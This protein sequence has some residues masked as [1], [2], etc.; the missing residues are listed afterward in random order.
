MKFLKT[1]KETFISSLPLVAIIII[2]CFFVE[3]M[4]NPGDYLKLSI[5]YIAVVVGQTIFLNGLDFSILPIGKLVGGSLGKIKKVSI[6]LLIGFL[7]GLLATVAEPAIIVLARQTNMIMGVIKENVFIWVSSIGIGIFVAFSLYRILRNF[8]IKI[9]FLILYVIIFAMILFVPQEFIALAFDGSG[10]TT[11]DISVPFILALGL[12][13][14]ATMSKTKT[15]EDTFGIIGLAS[16]GPIIALF[17][18]GIIMKWVHGGS[19]PPSGIYNPGD[20]GSL[21]E[22][23]LSNIGGVALTIIPIILVFLPFQFL[24]I[25]LNKKELSSLML[26]MMAVFIGLLIFLSGIDYGFAFAGKY[27]GEVFLNPT[28]PEWFKWMLLIVAFVLGAAITFTEPAVTILGEQLETTTNGHIKKSTIRV[29]LAIGIGFASLLAM[30]KILT[31]I[32]IV[33][34]LAPLYLIALIMMKF[35]SK[36]FVGLAFDSGGVTG[37]ALTSAF[38]TPLTLGAAQAIAVA[39]GEGAQSV[40]INGFGI[41]AFVSVTPLIAVQALG[42]IYNIQLK[43]QQKNIEKAGLAE[44]SELALLAKGSIDAPVVQL[45]SIDE[46]AEPTNGEEVKDND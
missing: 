28:R 17:I 25:K 15:N 12:G 4:K 2:V 33:W 9:V 32:N 8:N 39:S 41:I 30:V 6:I 42:I 29:T 43:K 27:I 36:L 24:L 18:Y 1:L 31:Q 40:L 21:G 23:I 26:G 46:I 45:E 10:A 34:F 11:G 35:S 16:T 44:L 37:G 3:P 38:L 20:A 7:F 22:I 14:S 5:G 19:L 13:A